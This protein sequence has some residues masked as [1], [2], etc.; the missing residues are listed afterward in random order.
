MYAPGS[1]G[2]GA[3]PDIGARI[4]SDPLGDSGSAMG[5]RASRAAVMNSR[6]VSYRSPG[7]LA[8]TRA[9]TSSR[10]GG[11]SGRSRVGWVGDSSTCAQMIAASRSFSNGT[12]PVRHS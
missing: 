8:S 9:N 11:R 12:R 2:Y 6:Q 3:D 1:A 4:G 10:A 7:C 5:P